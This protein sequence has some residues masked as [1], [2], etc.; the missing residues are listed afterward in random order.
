MRMSS[1]HAKEF[2]NILKCLGVNG[3][4]GCD[5]IIIK[6]GKIALSTN[7]MQFK[8]ELDVSK[9]INV[10]EFPIIALPKYYRVGNVIEGFLEEGKPFFIKEAGQYHYVI[11]DRFSQQYITHMDYEEA[12]ELFEQSIT[13]YDDSDENTFASFDLT[14]AMVKK[15]KSN[16]KCSTLGYGA[17]AYFVP[18]K[19]KIFW[20]MS[21]NVGTINSLLFQTDF[22]KEVLD[23]PESIAVGHISFAFLDNPLVGSDIHVTLHKSRKDGILIMKAVTSE[24][25]PFKISHVLQLRPLLDTDNTNELIESS[26]QFEVS[27][28][29]YKD[30]D[31]F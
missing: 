11:Y 12:N 18:D 19:E 5:A 31:D 2:F 17:M 30:E 13:K 26:G 7:G 16:A 6:N 3:E 4:A 9:Y 22:R 29:A 8:Y 27:E 23:D 20:R 1:A 24:I 10:D 14:K 21:D 15:I 28:E 25:V